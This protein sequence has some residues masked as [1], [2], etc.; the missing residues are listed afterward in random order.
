MS[1]KIGNIV[2]Y[3]REITVDLPPAISIQYQGCALSLSKKKKKIIT[4]K[5]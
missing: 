2:L 3:D 5:T 1:F 4:N